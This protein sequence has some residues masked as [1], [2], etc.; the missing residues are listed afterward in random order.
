MKSYEPEEILDYIN[1]SITE[2]ATSQDVLDMAKQEISHAAHAFVYPEYDPTVYKRRKNAG[3][4]SD[5]NQYD[6]MVSIGKNWA[7]IHISDFRREA[8]VVE[9]GVGYTWRNSLIYMLQ[10]FPRPYFSRAE[11][12]FANE[13]EGRL[14]SLV[15]VL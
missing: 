2:F 15:H 8:G 5:V 11:E 14:Y 3:G 1:K 6:E 7:E 12:F 4:L 13:Y 10:P 9:R